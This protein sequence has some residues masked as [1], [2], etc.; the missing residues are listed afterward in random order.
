MLALISVLEGTC[1]FLEGALL[2]NPATLVETA[3]KLLTE[4]TS[5]EEA[6]NFNVPPVRGRRGNA[7]RR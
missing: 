5:D 2:S 4:F 6:V 7:I 1:T 3:G